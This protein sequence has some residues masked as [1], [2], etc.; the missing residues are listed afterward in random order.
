[1]SAHPRS[2]WR[3][4][5]TFF[6]DEGGSEPLE[7]QR[8]LLTPEVLLESI[9]EDLVVRADVREERHGRAEFEMVRI[10]EYLL[11]AASLDGVHQACALAKPRPQN[12]VAHV[13]FGFAARSY[14]EVLGRRALARP[15]DLRKYEPHPMTRLAARAQLRQDRLDHR[16]L[17]LDESLETG[18]CHLAPPR[19]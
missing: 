4:A 13:G 15:P 18:R 16:L 19:G 14:G 1:M 6:P 3:F 5:A 12:R 8:V 2:S 17:R 9:E 11:D 7:G 10:A